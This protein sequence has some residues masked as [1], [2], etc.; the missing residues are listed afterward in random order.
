MNFSIQT[1][2]KAAKAASRQVA[3]LSGPQKEA[4]LLSIADILRANTSRILVANE[5]DLGEGRANGLDSAMLDRLLLNSDRINAIA[6]AVE[7]IA[8]QP[9]PVGAIANIERMP[10]GIQ[11][12]KMRIPLGVIAMIYESRPNVTI[13][14]A[15]LC[16]KAGNAVIL[17]GG[18][19]ALHSNLA[20]ASCI[21]K[22]LEKHG[23]DP[24]A[25]TVVPNPDRAV[26]QDMMTLEQDIDL[27]IPR[28]GEGLIRFVSSNSQIPVIQHYKGVCHLYVAEHASLTT[29]E[30]LL[31]NGKTQRTGVCNALETLL[32]DRRIADAFLPRANAVFSRHKVRVHA[33]ESSR[34]YFDDAES[35]VEGDW[36]AEYLAME[37]AVRVVDDYDAALEHIMTYGSG[38]TEVIATENY[39]QAQRFL[40]EVDSAVVMVNASSRFSDGGEL[41]LGAEIGI[42]TSKLHAYGP[43]GAASLTTEKFIVLGEGHVRA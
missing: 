40:R 11:V 38:H 10:S 1:A 23:I 13:D 3:R 39:A 24:A 12:G 34:P 19:E 36:H 22:A 42:S 35:A 32:V 43:M 41:G 27:I 26:M 14:A 16:L 18:K 29:A 25:V 21:H 4:L 31:E 5:K 37:I 9:D 15:A 33:C 6:L 20:L 8:A 30:A 7:A 17:R 28:G 2:A